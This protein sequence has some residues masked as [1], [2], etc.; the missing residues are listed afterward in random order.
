[1]FPL[2]PV[3]IAPLVSKAVPKAVGTSLTERPRLV[4]YDL[5]LL[6]RL[7]AIPAPTERLE[8]LPL[9]TGAVAGRP[10]E[11]GDFGA[12]EGIGTG[13]VPDLEPFGRFLPSVIPGSLSGPGIV[14]EKPGSIFLPGL[15]VKRLVNPGS[16]SAISLFL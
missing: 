14:L 2:L 1:L 8:L 7:V 15:G 4:T 10:G 5:A 11:T 9:S 3:D 6:K 13:V 16:M 12:V